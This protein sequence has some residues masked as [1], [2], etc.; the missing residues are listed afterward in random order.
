MQKRSRMVDASGLPLEPNRGRAQLVHVGGPL[1]GCARF[2]ELTV[3]FG[4]SSWK[5]KVAPCTSRLHT[6]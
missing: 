6:P 5:L 1:G 4:I 3:P 2:G